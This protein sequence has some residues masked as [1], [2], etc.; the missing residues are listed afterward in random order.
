MSS[1]GLLVPGDLDGLSATARHIEEL[2]A[3]CRETVG[4][5]AAHIRALDGWT[6]EGSDAWVAS[7]ERTARAAVGIGATLGTAAAVLDYC[8]RSIGELRQRSLL[9]AVRARQAG[10]VI[11]PDGTV[12]GRPGLAPFCHLVPGCTPEP[13]RRPGEPLLMAVE[14]RW[15]AGLDDSWRA[16]QFEIAALL[17]DAETV[18][19]AAVAGLRGIVADY[20]RALPSPLARGPRVPDGGGWVLPVLDT[21]AAVA[22]LP[23]AREELRALLH[24]HANAGYDQ[25]GRRPRRLGRAATFPS[26]AARMVRDRRQARAQRMRRTGKTLD[27][28]VDAIGRVPFLS[29]L[30]S[31]PVANVAPLRRVPIANVI[32][33]GISVQENV[34]EKGYSQ[35]GAVAREATV[36]VSGWAAASATG[37]VMIVVVGAPPAA[38]VVV[39]AGVGYA[40]GYVA[41][42]LIDKITGHDKPPAQRPTEPAFRERRPPDEK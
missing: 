26:E 23:A 31:A 15:L 42:W 27:A 16:V 30:A 35:G 9:L 11:E 3:E 17:D 22:Q 21:A 18:Y 33:A 41:G 39:A 40:V 19:L 20:R 28:L 8:G 7:A 10:L 5:Q 1:P 37:A 12:W 13:V 4:R 2:A 32:L 34:S 36:A 6:G 25:T 14:D 29:Q 38:A 24:R